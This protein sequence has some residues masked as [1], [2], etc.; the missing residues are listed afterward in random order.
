MSIGVEVAVGP[1]R[2]GVRRVNA[3]VEVG[4]LGSTPGSLLQLLIGQSG[5]VGSVHLGGFGT[6]G[7]LVLVLVL[8]LGQVGIGNGIWDLVAPR[9]QESGHRSKHAVGEWLNVHL[10]ATRSVAQL[11]I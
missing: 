2:R 9:G 8:V 3:Q 1:D 11:L 5:T 10:H 6:R 4:L 7:V